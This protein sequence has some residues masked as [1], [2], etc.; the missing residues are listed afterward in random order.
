MASSR[1]ATS[2][3]LPAGLPVSNCA[4]NRRAATSPEITGP[5]DT[6]AIMAR[7]ADKFSAMGGNT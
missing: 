6:Q 1:S 4:A 3:A 5:C 7:T 2:T